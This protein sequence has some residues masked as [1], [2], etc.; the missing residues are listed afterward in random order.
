MWLEFVRL[1]HYTLL[2][3]TWMTGGRNGKMQMVE[4]AESDFTV[5]EII[6]SMSAGNP[7]VGAIVAYVGVVRGFSEGGEVAGIEFDNNEAAI[8]KVRALAGKALEDFE[9]KDVAIVHRVGRLDVGDKLL[10]I[11]VSASH[12]QTAFDACTRMIDEIKAIHSS[13]TKEYYKDS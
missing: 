5:E 7:E 10:L 2:I 11:A 12:R 9:I 1:I 13:W 8:N 6:G 3:A 4:I